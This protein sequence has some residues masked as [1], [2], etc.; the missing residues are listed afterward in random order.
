MQGPDQLV[1]PRFLPWPRVARPHWLDACRHFAWRHP[2]WWSLALSVCAWTLLIVS[3]GSHVDHAT[4]GDVLPPSFAAASLR[5][6]GD[7]LV[8]VVAMMTPLVTSSIRTTAARSLWR[9]RH[10][11]I[12]AFLVGYVLPWA[13]VGLPVAAFSVWTRPAASRQLPLAVSAAFL[14][15]AAWQLAPA[16]RRALVACHRTAPI[17][18]Y[19]WRATRDAVRYGRMIGATCLVSCLPLMLVCAIAGHSLA[20][21][22][23]ATAVGVAE[24]S[25]PKATART[26]AAALV[27][28]GLLTLIVGIRP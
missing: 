13:L 22:A 4:H 24:R 2:E 8:M 14:V 10:R 3:R 11:A 21:M 28:L 15:A 7:W 27:V 1:A 5:A 16:K 17:A 18:P 23:A 20:P 6:L 9:R 25:T 19:G 26:T 12:A